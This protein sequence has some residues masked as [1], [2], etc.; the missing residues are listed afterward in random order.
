MGPAQPV[1]VQQYALRVLK[2]QQWLSGSV[3]ALLDPKGRRD[4]WRVRIGTLGRLSDQK[5]DAV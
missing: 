4:G 1:E 3:G 2:L 5:G